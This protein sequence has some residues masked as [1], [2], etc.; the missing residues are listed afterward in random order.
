MENLKPEVQ[1]I[2]YKIQQEKAKLNLVY[3]GIFSV[4]MLFAGLTS[5]YIVSMGSAFWL[6]AKF[7][8]AFWVSTVL[9]ISSSIA[10][11]IAI[12]GAKKGNSKLLKAAT[13]ITLILGLGFVYFQF[14]GYGQLVDQGIHAV[15]N[16]IV[17]DGKYGDYYDVKKDGKFIEVNG[18]DFLIAGKKMSD[19]EL[20]DY[21]VFMSQFLNADI[22]KQFEV[23]DYG[24][25]FEL[26]FKNEKMLFLNNQLVKADS[27]E[28]VYLDRLRLSYLAQHV[29]DE[30]GDFFVKGEMGKDFHIY[31]KG[32]EL[33]YKDRQLY[34]KGSKLKGYLQIK[35]MEAAD[36]SSSYLYLITVMH[37]LHI[38]VTLFFVIRIVIR[39]FT[40]NINQS[41]TIGLR[42]GAIFW[43]FLG[44][45]WIYLLLFLLFIH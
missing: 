25:H 10:I 8:I 34:L 2:D 26:I 28:M 29:R 20:N 4:I 6:K 40:G 22:T 38:I 24:K 36:T 35:A 42:V 21:K 44:L 33:N 31:Y 23:K 45:L 17:T 15:G 32:E 5:A 3:V 27:T 16:I 19:K 1:E 41:N 11:Q 7:P 9:I 37:L 39:S 13:L 18:N 43:H 14:K 12:K 30:R